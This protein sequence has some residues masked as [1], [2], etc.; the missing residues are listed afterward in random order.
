MRRFWALV[1]LLAT[2]AF[3]TACNDIGIHSRSTGSKGSVPAVKASDFPRTLTDARGQK[4]TLQ[5]PPQR[6]VSL[7]PSGTEVFYALGAGD[8]IAAVTAADDY[9]PEVKQKPSIANIFSGDVE[10]LLAQKPDLVV[11]VG[12][13]NAKPI[14]ALENLHVP[15][16]V[17]EPKN[18]QETYTAIRLQGQAVGAEAKADQIVS[19]MQARLAAIQKIVSQA[20]SRPR[21][22]ILYGTDPIYTTG[23]GSFIDDLITLAGGQNVVDRPLSG[24]ILSAEEV[25]VRKPDVILCSKVLA[26]KVRNMPG[27]AQSVPAVKNGRLYFDEAADGT[28]VRPTPRLVK[29]VEALARYLH[30]ELDWKSL[31]ASGTRP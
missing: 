13:L 1:G 15:V 9:P 26:E 24:N 28:L 22:L 11:A 31:D 3:G 5:S 30:P 2:V 27:W 29:G 17:V 25:V 10:P 19:E 6:I 18:L 21:V 7:I 14:A 12:S 20:K 4:L 23:P 8:R 16:L